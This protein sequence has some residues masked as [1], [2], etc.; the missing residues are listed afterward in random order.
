MKKIYLDSCIF[1]YHFEKHPQFGEKASKIFQATERGSHKIVASTLV[2]HELMSGFS[3]EN[4]ALSNQI[5][6]LLITHPKIEWTDFN[7]D[8]AN[9]SA[10]LRADL[11]LKT[12]DAIHLATAIRSQCSKFYTEDRQLKNQ[13]LKLPI[14][15]V[16]V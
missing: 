10:L 6:G 14:E 12:P 11:G 5:Y 16:G 2:M 13:K 3:S 4:D 15:I 9:T 8:L 1:I 7:L